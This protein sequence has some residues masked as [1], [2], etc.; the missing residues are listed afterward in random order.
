[1]KTAKEYLQKKYPSMRG[2]RWNITD[3][4][5]EW[6]AKQMEDYHKAMTK[7]ELKRFLKF[8]NIDCENN[9]KLVNNYLK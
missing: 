4:D 7:K 8:L 1:M 5:D 6:V 9:E 2:Y 3:I